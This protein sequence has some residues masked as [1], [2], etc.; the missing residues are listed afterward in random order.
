MP[1]LSLARSTLGGL[2]IGWMFAHLSFAIPVKRL[3]E[4]DTLLAFYHPVPH[5]SINPSS[6]DPAHL[7]SASPGMGMPGLRMPGLPRVWINHS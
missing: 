4:T 6:V 1:Y 2:I 7:A 3:R 5:P